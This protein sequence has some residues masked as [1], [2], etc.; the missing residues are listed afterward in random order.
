[1][2]GK[3]AAVFFVSF[4]LQGLF[5]ICG[6]AAINPDENT[7]GINLGFLSPTGTGDMKNTVKSGNLLGASWNHNFAE[8]VTSI[9]EINYI[10]FGN[11]AD[12]GIKDVS[13]ISIPAIGRYNFTPDRASTPYLLIGIGLNFVSKKVLNTGYYSYTSQ[14]LK[15]GVGL[16][17]GGGFEW[18]FGSW[19]LGPEVRYQ[20]YATGFGGLGLLV[21]I[22]W[23][24]EQ[25]GSSPYRVGDLT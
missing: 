20:S 1:M 3:V 2:S 8:D 25:N 13:V 6:S 12:A 22:A 23:A 15:T 7:F 14:S 4:L 11:K 21:K 9:S 16:V 24:Y 5:P 19:Y 10:T 17:A 18:N